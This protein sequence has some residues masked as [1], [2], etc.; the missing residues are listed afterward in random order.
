MND[1]C[2]GI[3]NLNFRYKFVNVKAK[4]KQKYNLKS[5]AFSKIEELLSQGWQTP[6]VEDEAAAGAPV[7]ALLEGAAAA[8]VSSAILVSASAIVSS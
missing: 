5:I 6:T 3:L 1:S 8:L 2:E 7:A 4:T